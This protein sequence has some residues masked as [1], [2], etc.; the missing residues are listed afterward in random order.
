VE[1][2]GQLF[3]LVGGFSVRGRMDALIFSVIGRTKAS[4]TRTV[5][6]KI[7]RTVFSGAYIS[8]R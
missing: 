1:V 4:E 5:A 6:I 8:S 3:D 7:R 2:L